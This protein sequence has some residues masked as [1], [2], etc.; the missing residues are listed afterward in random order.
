M[1]LKI[2]RALKTP[3][4][5]QIRSQLK[6]QI[7][8]GRLSDGYALPSERTLAKDLGVH[9]NT[10]VRAYNELKADGLLSSYQGVGYRVACRQEKRPE[11]KSG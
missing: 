3:V 2:D 8:S 5:I 6:E 11:K 7:L 1:N 4:Y 10:V 9:R